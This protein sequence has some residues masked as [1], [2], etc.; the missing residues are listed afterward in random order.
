MDNYKIIAVISNIIFEPYFI[1]LIKS[2]FGDNILIFPIPY[3]E[4][5]DETYKKQLEKCNMIIIWLNFESL[6]SNIINLAYSN[7]LGKQKIDEAVTLCEKL[8]INLS[9]YSNAR[10]LWFLFEDYYSHGS[11]I[12]GDKYCSFVDEINVKLC[13]KLDKHV[14]FIN[15]KHMIAEIGIAN[16][17]NMKGKYRWNAPYS[18]SLIEIAV[19]EIHKEYLTEKGITKKCLVLDCDNVLWGGIL[20]EDGI[21]NLK[22]GGSGF[23]RL[24]QD[25]QKFVLSLYYHGVILAVCS[26]NNLSDVLSM[27]NEHTEMILKEENIAC[28]QVNWGNKPDNIKKISETLNIGLDSMVFIDDS[29]VEIESVKAMLPEVIAIQYVHDTIYEQLSCFN[30]KSEINIADIE[31]RNE[32]YRTSQSREVLKSQYD[33]YK[34]YINALD[35]KIDI[36]M[37]LPIEYSRISEL[38][39]RTNKCTNGKRYTVSQIKEMVNAD[40]ITLY[41]LSVSDNFSDL[42]L[43]GVIGIEENT[44]S[45][46][47]LSCRALGREIEEKMITYIADRHEINDIEF[48]S[49]GRNED[50][51]IML[52]KMFPNAVIK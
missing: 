18:R 1:P 8:F 3:E 27:F 16:A 30:L 46:F 40:N 35:I 10:I 37:S 33:S 50:I 22:L 34:D 29:A 20:S 21:E 49:T 7:N 26:K 23:G 13:D 48:S 14:F 24:Y 6:F 12:T 28:F 42:G 36:H 38:T 15:L 19:M 52:I 41:S 25:F 4:H 31:K 45:L 51:K 47:S 39:Q 2:R 44:L 11:T 5:N 43:V 17:Y 32:T 9:T